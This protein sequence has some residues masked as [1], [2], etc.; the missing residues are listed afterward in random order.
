MRKTVDDA[1]FSTYTGM[2]NCSISSLHLRLSKMDPRS[3][4]LRYSLEV[5][6]TD[7][8]LRL[9]I[10][11]ELCHWLVDRDILRVQVCS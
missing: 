4:R 9:C 10:T 6:E 8:M 5:M 1:E 3:T 7:G 2:R 11:R